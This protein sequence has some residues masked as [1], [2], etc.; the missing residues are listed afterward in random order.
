[1]TITKTNIVS[2]RQKYKRQ[3]ILLILYEFNEVSKL[4]QTSFEGLLFIKILVL[5]Y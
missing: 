3:I 1:M 2:V 5:I 4:F